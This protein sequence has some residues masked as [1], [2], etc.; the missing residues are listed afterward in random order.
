MT[1]PNLGDRDFSTQ[2]IGLQTQYPKEV[3]GLP[4]KTPLLT[5]QVVSSNPDA[6]QMAYQI[7]SIDEAG[8][9]FFSDPIVNNKSVDMPAIGHITSAGQIRNFRVRIATQKG[10][11]DFSPI[12][13]YETGLTSGDEFT[14]V[15]IGDDSL[16]SDPAPLL[17]K[18]FSLSKEVVK[19]RLYVTSDGLNN[20]YLNGVKVG[21]EYLTPGWTAFDDRKTYLTFDVSHLL[22]QGNNCISAEL[23]DGWTRGKF[24]WTNL[25]DLF[26]T[27]ISFLAHLEIT[28]IDGS[29]QV[30]DTDSSWKSSQGEIRFASIYDGST[31]D[32]N[33]KNS[34]WKNTNFNDSSWTPV[35]I[36]DYDKNILHPRISPAVK[37]IQ[38]FPVV[39]L[40]EGTRTLVDLTQNISGWLRLVVVGKRGDVITVRH[41]EILETGQKLH[42]AALRTAKA[43]DVYTLDHDGRHVLEPV[44]TFHGFQYA[45]IVSE[46]KYISS[47]GIAISSATEVRSKFSSSDSRLN[48]LYQNVIWSARDNFVSVPTDCPQRDERLGWTGDAQAFAMTANTLFNMTSFWRSWLVDLEIDQML[49]DG[50]IPAVV[51]NILRKMPPPFE[52]LTSEGRAG[53]A[54]AGT[55]VPWAT[56]ESYGTL[57]I[58][59][60][61]LNS[62]RAWVDTLDRRRNGQK[63][64]PTE[65]QFGDWC[66]PDAP[67]DMPWLSKV[68]ADFVA[69]AF[70]A[71]SAQLLADAEELVGTQEKK[72][73]YGKLAAKLRSDIWESM[74][75]EAKSTTAGCSI[76]LEFNIAPENERATVAKL[77]SDSVII[78]EGKITTGFLG[79]PLILNALSKS[80]YFEAAYLMLMRRK[81]RSWLYQVDQ[82]ATTIWER[83]DAIKEDG[84]IHT[85][86]MATEI[87]EQPDATMISFNHYA[88]GA[89]IDWVYRNVAGIA[90]M[91]EAPGYQKILF[92]P[93]PATGFTFANAAIKTPYGVAAID[94]EISRDNYFLMNVTIP[95]GTRGI[96][97]LPVSKD[98]EIY[99]NGKT[100]PNNS[101]FGFGI[102]AV[103]ISN[104]A[105][106]AISI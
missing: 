78:D 88:Y 43:T 95:F 74:G 59:A 57:D 71:H 11:S 94:W 8:K 28:Y 72:L 54:D 92:A 27:K 21:D 37:V 2:V 34:G 99:I 69:N 48:R 47:T 24:G 52:G 77:L 89:V 67:S 45:E 82:S 44:F 39:V 106:V 40:T 66:D 7:I 30:V 81:I 22:N 86:V 3:I 103:R 31:I 101:E 102:Y 55:I 84:S 25:Y 33:L 36:H 87:E 76:A 46:A 104:P 13:N 62:M 42:T 49:A 20:T 98:S 32:F 51:P 17:R 64:L 50:D 35:T 93:R 97:D 79:T 41:A 75:E 80:G 58:L 63:F 60:Q 5:W 73:K 19:G 100:V 1:V 38:E 70:F 90:P 53:W 12:A 91:L 18:E 61:Q 29:T 85:G 96:L 6:V 9:T 15:A 16:H 105:I 14:G 65:F 10:W 23:G 83:W 56:Y 26:G 68:S 4:I